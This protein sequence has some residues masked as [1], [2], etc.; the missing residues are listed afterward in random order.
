MRC[1]QIVIIIAIALLLTSCLPEAQKEE[2]VSPITEAELFNSSPSQDW[3]ADEYAI[4]YQ[5]SIRTSIE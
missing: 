4:D 5:D 3:I 2:T 1:L